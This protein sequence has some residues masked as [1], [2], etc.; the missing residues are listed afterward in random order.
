MCIRDRGKDSIRDVIAFPKTARGTDVMTGA[1]SPA[2]LESLVELGIKL[3]KPLPDKSA[4]SG[5]ERGESSKQSTEN[6][7][8]AH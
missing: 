7:P 8:A 4:P 5:H 3:T 2:D 6:K 1:P